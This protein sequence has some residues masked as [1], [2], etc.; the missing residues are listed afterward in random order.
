M[1]TVV[2]IIFVWWHTKHIW[3]L[4]SW[5]NMLCMTVSCHTGQPC[6]KAELL[7]MPFGDTLVWPEWT[8]MGY[9]W[10]PSGTYDWM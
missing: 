8:I 7:E 1:D 3:I 9:T 6:K 5:C 10:A 4:E 2:V